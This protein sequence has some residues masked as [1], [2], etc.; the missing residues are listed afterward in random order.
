[1]AA[2][3]HAGFD[4]VSLTHHAF[5]AECQSSAPFVVLAAIAARTSKLRLATII[6]R[7]TGS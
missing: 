7:V 3:E 1:M 4:F 6:I 2:A 5:S